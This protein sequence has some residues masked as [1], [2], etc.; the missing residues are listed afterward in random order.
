MKLKDIQNVIEDYGVCQ[1]HSDGAMGDEDNLNRYF[2]PEPEYHSGADAY[3]LADNT[4]QRCLHM[5]IEWI[6]S[7]LFPSDGSWVNFDIKNT[8]SE[9]LMKKKQI[10]LIMRKKLNETNFYSE[11]PSFVKQGLMWNLGLLD[12]RYKRGVYYCASNGRQLVTSPSKGNTQRAYTLWN[13]ST[14]ELQ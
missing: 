9:S 8:D 2:D 6:V 10:E 1:S 3:R 14:A 11:L 12:V 13:A 7:T 4:G 5:L